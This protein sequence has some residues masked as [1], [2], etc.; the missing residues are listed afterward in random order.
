MK[1]FLHG[2]VVVG[3]IAALLF[4][5]V[6]LLSAVLIAAYQCDDN[7]A[8]TPHGAPWYQKTDSWQWSVQLVPSLLGSG[9][10]ALAFYFS[11]R[12]KYSAA[13]ASLFALA[14]TFVGWFVLMS[15]YLFA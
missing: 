14:A 9:A 3:T 11:S 12:R 4:C 5:F 2:A 8:A 15:G 1:A 10:A 6:W 7:C 13:T